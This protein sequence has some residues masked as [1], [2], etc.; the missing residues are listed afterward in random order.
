MIG[1]DPLGVAGSSRIHEIC[2]GEGDEHEEH[3]VIWINVIQK[4]FG[5]IFHGDR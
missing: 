2:G 3:D 4:G 1:V 5:P